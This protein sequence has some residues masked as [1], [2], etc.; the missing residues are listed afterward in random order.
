MWNRRPV[1]AAAANSSSFYGVHKTTFEARKK[2]VSVPRQFNKRTQ[3]WELKDGRGRIRFIAKSRNQCLGWSNRTSRFP[4]R[5]G[6]SQGLFPPH[7]RSVAGY[8]H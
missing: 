2:G 4:E 3:Q 6:M 5:K 1:R 7:F 8:A